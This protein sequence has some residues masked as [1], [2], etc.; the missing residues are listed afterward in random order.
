MEAHSNLG[1]ALTA[2]GEMEAA[3]AAYD[4]ALQSRPVWSEAHYN[5]GCALRECGQWQSAES[6]FRT[7]L[8]LKPDLAVAENNLGLVLMKQG[9]L[10]AALAAFRQAMQVMPAN[11]SFHSNL[12]YALQFHPGY[13]DPAIAEEQRRWNRQFGDLLKQFI[14]PHANDRNPDRRLRIGYVSPG[15][16]AHVVGRYI[17]PLFECHDRERFEILCYSGVA[18]SDRMTECFHALAGQWRNTVGVPD[19]RLAEMIRADSVDILVDLTQ[20][21]EG[22]R[23]PMFARKPAPAQV[24]FAGYPE[25]TGLEAIEYRISDRYLEPGSANERTGRKE[26]VYLIDS[27]W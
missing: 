11:A 1:N 20:H 10:E 15:F 17:L 13:S 19:A 25:S 26:H 9:C 7:A 27:F 14:L 5:K 18:R 4:I 12:V 6:A 22:N 3:I 23:L 21:K 8:R 2:I 24:S 16:R